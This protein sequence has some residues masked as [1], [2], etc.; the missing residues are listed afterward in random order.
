MITRIITYLIKQHSMLNIN[1]KFVI[2]R[3]S[4]VFLKEKETYIFKGN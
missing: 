4:L 2:F 1:I 3:S